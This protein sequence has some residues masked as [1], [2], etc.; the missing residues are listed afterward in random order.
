MILDNNFFIE[1]IL[2]VAIMRKLTDD[3]MNAYR[4][5]FLEKGESRRPMLTFARQ[6]I[7]LGRYHIYRLLQVGDHIRLATTSH[8]P[9][10]K[11]LSQNYL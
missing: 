9:N 7:I 8:F 11:S 3:E 1:Q 6:L 2:P 10:F 5:P 4:K